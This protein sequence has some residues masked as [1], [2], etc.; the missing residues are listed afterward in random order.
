MPMETSWPYIDPLALYRSFGPSALLRI[1]SG[2]QTAKLYIGRL[3]INNFFMSSLYTSFNI[4][5][6]VLVLLSTTKY[7]PLNINKHK[8]GEVGEEN[9]NT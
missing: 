8:K 2:P 6:S 1:F 9:K 3:Y 7:K 4:F 5:S